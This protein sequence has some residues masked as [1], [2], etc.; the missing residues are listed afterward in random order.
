MARG[1]R[2]A[3]RPPIVVIE[4]RKRMSTG[5]RKGLRQS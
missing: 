2:L 3:S 5:L 4:T 1:G